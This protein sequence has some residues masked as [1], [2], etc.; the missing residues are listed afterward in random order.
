MLDAKDIL[1]WDVHNWSEILPFWNERLRTLDRKATNVL[2]LGE[3]EG[4]LSVWLA[5]QGFRVIC[6][7]I[8]GIRPEVVARHR[9]FNFAHQ[10]TYG[11]VNVFDMPY[12]DCHFHLVVCKSVIGGLKLRRND[13]AT[14]TLD[15]QRKA[16]DE[17]RRVLK[18][19]GLFLG[20]E[21]LRGHCAL[22]IARQWHKKGRV[23]WRH[24]T[25]EE[26]RYLFGSFAR[27]ETKCFGLVPGMFR[28]DLMNR[29]V[30]RFNRLVD[31]FAPD[32]AKYICGIIAQK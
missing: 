29:C 23:G 4:G 24:L 5:S 2:A 30:H 19:G 32:D 1:S 8:E 17:I 11:D 9:Q 14:R 25:C 28:R 31:A 10:L 12:D 20:A 27:V 21:N 26:I 7:D 13:P 6:S 15:N 22:R 16:V 3:R 18:P